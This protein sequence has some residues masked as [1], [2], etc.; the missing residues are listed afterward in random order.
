MSLISWVLKTAHLSQHDR[1][2]V[3]A[4]FCAMTAKNWVRDESRCTVKVPRLENFQ[5]GKSGKEG[6]I[7][8]TQTAKLSS[9]EPNRVVSLFL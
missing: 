1:T 5:E 2:G 3:S 9:T 7:R 4:V 8:L 6:T